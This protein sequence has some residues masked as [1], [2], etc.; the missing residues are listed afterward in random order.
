MIKT[1][2]DEFNKM[3]KLSLIFL[4][5]SFLASAGLISFVIFVIVKLLQHFYII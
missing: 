4:I 2:S 1:K 5:I 3:F